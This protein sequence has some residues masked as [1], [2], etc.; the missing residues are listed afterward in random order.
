MGKFV[1]PLIFFFCCLLVD[2][3][4]IVLVALMYLCRGRRSKTLSHQLKRLN[5][6]ADGAR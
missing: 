3:R 5:F 4:P 6:L 2:F 1:E